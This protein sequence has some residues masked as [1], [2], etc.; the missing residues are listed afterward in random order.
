MENSHLGRNR[1]RDVESVVNTLGDIWDEMTRG[2][3]S[4]GHD[5]SN[6]TVSVKGLYGGGGYRDYS[7]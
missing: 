2:L 1:E 4:S 6:E 5:E 7:C 3:Y